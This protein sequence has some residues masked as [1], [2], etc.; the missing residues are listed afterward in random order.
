MDALKP[1]LEP[2]RLASERGLGWITDAWKLFMQAP[3][4]WLLI[5][6][7]SFGVMFVTGL[8]PLVGS[9]MSTFVNTLLMAGLLQVA[10]KQQDGKTPEVGAL[11]DILS[12]PRLKPL[13]I[14][15]LIFLALIFAA[16]IL[17]GML[18]GA[19][20]GGL[21][22]LGGD[23]SAIAGASLLGVLFVLLLVTPVMAM[24][25]F[26][27]PLVLFRGIEPWDAMKTSLT[28]V[29]ANTMPLL[30]YGVLSLLLMVVSMIPL[31]LG[32]LVFFPLM[33]ISWLLSYREMFEE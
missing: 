6:L 27:V 9:L 3:G 22:L 24:Y 15:A 28:A 33:L 10:R 4:Q 12:D 26:A 14:T 29:I 30:V 18:F 5:S 20:A 1:V 7:V 17:G 21:A 2:R 16:G 13:L 25:W 32:L 8:V 19:G 31:G 11:F 23:G